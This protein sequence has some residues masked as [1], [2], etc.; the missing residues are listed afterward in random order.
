MPQKAIELILMRHLASYLPVPILLI[1]PTGNLLFYNKPAETIIGRRYEE[2]GE[3][4]LEEWTRILLVTTKDGL[5]IPPE[6][7]PLF[8]A[9]RKHRAVHR[10]CQIRGL[11][12]IF[13]DIEVTAFP[14]EGQEGRLLGAVAIFWELNFI[15]RMLKEKNWERS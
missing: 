5:P 14:L 11:D 3:I 4:S 6:D 1:D 13:R 7:R 2:T 10:T 8:I 9:L 15:G 12:G